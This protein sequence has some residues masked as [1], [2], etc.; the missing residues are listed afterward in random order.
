M[1]ILNTQVLATMVNG[2][3]VYESGEL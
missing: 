3:F 2:S 1:D